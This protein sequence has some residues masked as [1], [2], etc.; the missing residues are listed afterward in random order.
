MIILFIIVLFCLYI[1]SIILYKKQSFIE[2]F[3]SQC[4]RTDAGIPNTI[5]NQ[6]LFLDKKLDSLEGSYSPGKD[7]NK[8]K[9]IDQLNK[10]EKKYDWMAN[11]YAKIINPDKKAQANANAAAE[12]KILSDNAKNQALAKAKYKKSFKPGAGA[13]SLDAGSAE[14]KNNFRKAQ[15]DPNGRKNRA[16]GGMKK[17]AKSKK[18]KKQVAKAN[19]KGPSGIPPKQNTSVPSGP[20]ISDNSFGA[21]FA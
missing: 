12:K 21:A 13:L 1:Y 19:G 11:H 7:K 2:M 18:E 10:M 9:Y 3:N 17:K 15:K 20:T 16:L 14:D 8:S 4:Q 5:Y 6:L